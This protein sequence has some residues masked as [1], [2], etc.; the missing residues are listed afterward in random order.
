MIKPVAV[1]TAY[2]GLLLNGAREAKESKSKTGDIEASGMHRN[3]VREREK[4][5]GA[6]RT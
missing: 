6:A 1:V 2:C 4:E 3:G 5:R